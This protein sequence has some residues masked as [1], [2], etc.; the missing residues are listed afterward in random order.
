MR[1]LATLGLMVAMMAVLTGHVSAQ[2]VVLLGPDSNAG[3]YSTSQLSAIATAGDTVSYGGLTGISLWGFLGGANASSPTSPI[4]GDITTSTP[5]GDNGKNAI[6]RYYLLGTGTGGVQTAV[7][8][9][10]IDPNFGG[11]AANNPNGVPF[12]AFKNTGGSMLAAPELVV[13]GGAGGTGSSA[14]T[15]LSALQLLSVPAAPTGPGGITTSFVLSG[16]VAQ[17]G[18]YTLQSLEINFTPIQETVSGDTYRGIP[19]F[20]FLDATSS[21]IN[22]QLVVALGSDGYEVAYSLSELENLTD[23]LPYADSNGTLPTGS[24][25]LARTILPGDSAH[26]RWES[27]L[28]GLSV[29]AAGVPGPLAGAGLPGLV[30]ASGAIGWLW[31]RSRKTPVVLAV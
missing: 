18:T 11:T 7:S 22:D 31:R 10:Q 26:G 14:L 6:F 29:Q 1:P 3:S 15:N 25:G 28:V 12:I 20:D 9:G 24:S 5:A 4:Y 27:N 30:F 2:A 13:P 19:L 17:P 21:A 16:N 8:L 23:I